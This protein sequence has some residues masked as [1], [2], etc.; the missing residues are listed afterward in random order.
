MTTVTTLL[1]CSPSLFLSARAC[2]SGVGVVSVLASAEE[3]S[4]PED[5][6]SDLDAEEMREIE[7]FASDLT[8][9]CADC[10]RQR[11]EIRMLFEDP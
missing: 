1:A 3:I 4:D 11:P 9:V 5:S 7:L 6:F 8:R 2:F 10:L